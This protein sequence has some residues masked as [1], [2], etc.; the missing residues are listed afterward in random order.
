MAV[1]VYNQADRAHAKRT[2]E[3]VLT[4]LASPEDLNKARKVLRGVLY[5]EM[6]LELV[7]GVESAKL[8][9]AYNEIKKTLIA[10]GLV[11]EG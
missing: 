7:D 4:L 8:E 11:T 3:E 9:V 1:N 10:Q 2:A 5:R 6:I